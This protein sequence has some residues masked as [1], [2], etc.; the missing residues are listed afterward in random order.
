MLT[1]DPP[2]PYQRHN[3]RP[4]WVLIIAAAIITIVLVQVFIE[5]T[6]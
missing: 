3:R 4:D 5:L 6:R 1:N 2:V